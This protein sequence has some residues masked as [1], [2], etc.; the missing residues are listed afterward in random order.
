MHTDSTL[1]PPT[2]SNIETGP[3]TQLGAGTGRREAQGAHR[4]NMEGPRT[5]SE[6]MSETRKL[7][8]A[9]VHGLAS[10]QSRPCTRSSQ[11]CTRRNNTHIHDAGAQL[12]QNQEAAA[13][14]G[15]TKRTTHAKP[16]AQRAAWSG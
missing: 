8:R 16:N 7:G 11:L 5:L 9:H 10:H 4:P 15:P 2:A 1:A 6:G 12:Q 14:R 13:H 3:A